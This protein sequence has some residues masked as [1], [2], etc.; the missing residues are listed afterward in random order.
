[1]LMG[2]KTPVE[3]SHRMLDAFVDAG[4]T[5]VDTA[6]TYGNGTSERVP[7][8][9]AG[10]C[11]DDAGLA[12]EGRLATDDPPG[13]GLAPDRIRAACD[14][15]LRRLGV[16]VIDLY[17]VHAPDPDVPLEATLEALDGLVGAGKVRAL[18]ASN[19][20]AWLL[21]WAVAL[22]DRNGWG[23]VGFPPRPNPPPRAARLGRGPA[24][25]PAAGGRCGSAARGAPPCAPGGRSAPGSSPAATAATSRCRTAAGWR[26]RPTT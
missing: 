8:P 19:F 1:M 16:D 13:E 24:A 7:A 23:A 25:G 17:Q 20:P 22:Q 3:E 9:W 5:L 12:A 2:E 6:D 21:A 15:S 10:G 4:G 26:P 18:G 11:R 14:A